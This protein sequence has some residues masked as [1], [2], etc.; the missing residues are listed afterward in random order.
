MGD[1][2]RPDWSGRLR[3]LWRAPSADVS[4]LVVSSPANIK[5]LCGFDGSAGLVVSSPERTWLLVDGRYDRSARLARAAG[6][7]ADV[8][9]ATMT[10]SLERLLS[11]LTSNIAAGPIGFEA[12][13]VTVATLMAWE[14]ACPE[15]SFIATTNL[16]ERLRII[17]ES[18]ELDRIR[19][20]CRLTSDIVRELGQWVRAGRTERAIAWDIDNAMRRAGATRPAFDTIVASG[21]NSALPHAR[22]TDRLLQ[23][24]DLVVLDFGGVLDGYCGDLTRMA[25]VGEVTTEARGLF[26]A[27]RAA[28]VAALAAV[29]A[30]APVLEV[31]AAARRVLTT[32][33]FGDA[34]LHATGHGLGLEVHEAPR[35][36]RRSDSNSDRPGEPSDREM[37]RLAAGMVCTIEPGA[38]VEGIGGV[39]LEDDVVVTD[40]GCE[41][42]TEAPRDLLLV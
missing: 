14:R 2:D 42:L 13:H 40:E 1:F 26:D 9:V 8:E 25:G 15:R 41:V 20:A 19:R 34:F 11:T 38:Y 23:S 29:R 16:I 10:G 33:G 36:G 24:G 22:P 39:R 31:D 5:Y 32:H 6:E 30:E 27:V 7:L 28:Q 18:A 12:Q 17:K 35:L 21:P 37:D 3:R 4:A